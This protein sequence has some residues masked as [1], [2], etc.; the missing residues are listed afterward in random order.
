[1]SDYYELEEQLQDY[2]EMSNDELGEFVKMLLRIRNEC[3]YSLLPGFGKI[4]ES[5]LQAQLK[6]FK[7][8]S[9]VVKKDVPISYTEHRVY[10]EWKRPEEQVNVVDNCP[11]HGPDSSMAQAG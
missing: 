8:N 9:T 3:G 11:I 4:V 1:M 5:E 2:A 7:E 6:N 10:L